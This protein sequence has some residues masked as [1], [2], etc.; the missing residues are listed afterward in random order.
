MV[1]LVG[2]RRWSVCPGVDD[3]IHL[4]TNSWIYRR[5]RNEVESLYAVRLDS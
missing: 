4:L 1:R 3:S 2:P 5:M